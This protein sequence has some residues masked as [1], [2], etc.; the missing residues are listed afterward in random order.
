MI[1]NEA[2]NPQVEETMHLRLFIDRPHVHG[3]TQGVCS[4]NE[5]AIDHADYTHL[6]RNLNCPYPFKRTRNSQTRS[7]LGELGRGNEPRHRGNPQ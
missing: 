1:S 4:R 5:T 6:L 3:T 2:V 7:R